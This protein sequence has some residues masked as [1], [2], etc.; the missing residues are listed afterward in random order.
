[1]P[2]KFTLRMHAENQYEWILR[3]FKCNESHMPHWRF[4]ESRKQHRQRLHW[5]D[6]LLIL[7]SSKCWTNTK[8]IT[9]VYC[10]NSRSNNLSMRVLSDD[11]SLKNI[12]FHFQKTSV[13]STEVD[14]HRLSAVDVRRSL[15]TAPLVFTSWSASVS[16]LVNV[17]RIFRH[18]MDCRPVQNTG[19]GTRSQR[20]SKI[21]SRI[22]GEI[23]KAS[24][25]GV[26]IVPPSIRYN[27]RLPLVRTPPNR[28]STRHF[29]RHRLGFP[30]LAEPIGRCA[31][32]LDGGERR[33]RE[34]KTVA[35]FGCR[36][37]DVSNSICDIR[38]NL[39][40]VGNADCERIG[41]RSY[42]EGMATRAG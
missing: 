24:E 42:I 11:F 12:F 5:H 37:S 10:A 19:N 20:R 38:W 4:T 1:M 2:Q 18:R 40:D 17:R 34:R 8:W 36:I 14:Y 33:S 9:D 26:F 28:H 13:A 6:V 32:R 21:R 41:V 27:G 16:I 23:A 25:A 29:L 7:I 3:E 22:R 39:L 15:W 35:L 30:A 31:G